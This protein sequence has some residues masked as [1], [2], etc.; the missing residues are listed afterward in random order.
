MNLP[1]FYRILLPLT[2]IAAY[3]F[4]A[5]RAFGQSQA[6]DF[7]PSKVAPQTAAASVPAPEAAAT[8]PA[9][10]PTRFV[11]DGSPVL[12]ERLGA[13]ITPPQGWEVVR[14]MPGLSLFIQEPQKPATGEPD[15]SKPV[16][17]RNITIAVSQ[18]ARPMDEAEAKLLKAKIA[19]EFQKNV[20]LK[21]FQIA[22]QHRFFN[23]HGTNDGL[24]IYATYTM[25]DIPMTQMHVIVTGEKEQVLLTYTD[26]TSEIEANKGAFE[27]AWNS[28]VSISVKGEPPQRFVALATFALAVLS[29]VG[30]LAGFGFVRRRRAKA[31]LKASELE[32]ALDDSIISGKTKVAA[33][34]NVSMSF[35]RGRGRASRTPRTTSAAMPFS[36]VWDLGDRKAS[37]HYHEEPVSEV[38][39]FV[40]KSGY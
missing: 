20:T 34:S 35:G 10:L 26:L 17:Q 21:D 19:T 23:H 13:N 2:G 12:I 4:D 15:Y 6:S 14:D 28:M 11:S 5:S 25:S 24:V 30:A 22:E 37:S 16:F 40:S 8:A 29:F 38:M 33:V 27:A 36:G 32:D 3:L 9:S 1:R 7:L 31:M 18:D 39:A